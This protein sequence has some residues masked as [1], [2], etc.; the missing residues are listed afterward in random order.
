M[1]DTVTQFFLPSNPSHFPASGAVPDYIAQDA[2]RSFNREPFLDLDGAIFFVMFLGLVFL[3]HLGTYGALIFSLALSAYL[4]VRPRELG[5]VIRQHWFFLLFPAYAMFSTLWSETPF[6]TLKH[7]AE[8][9]FTVLAALLLI[10]AKNQRSVINGLFLAFAVYSVISVLMG[11]E[12]AVGTS[13]TTAL[14][15]LDDSKNEQADSVTNGALISLLLLFSGLTARKASQCLLGLAIFL[16]Q[17]YAAI[18]ARSTGALAAFAA[19][20]GCFAVL[21]GFRRVHPRVRVLVVGITAISMM[22][23]ALAFLLFR[24]EVLQWLSTVFDKDATLTGRTYLWSRA[25]DLVAERPVFGRGFE[26]FWQQGN[27]DAEGLWQFGHI[28]TRR[29]FNFHNTMYDLLVELG[30]VGLTAFALT[31]LVGFGRAVSNYVSRPS[32]L[33][34]FWLSVG[35]HMVIR[36]PIET[37]G[38]YEFSFSTVLL[39]AMLA[40]TRATPQ[41][42][43][44]FSEQYRR[45]EPDEM[46]AQYVPPLAE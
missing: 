11:T 12:V 4:A 43:P 34:C 28:L 10:S 45:V 6:D 36:M 37:I 33:S 27:L 18:L 44:A 8:F 14:A 20:A 19:G 1:S 32:L 42:V 15:G 38:T 23:V 31:M 17:I 35:I 3:S 41:Y 26:A 7:A 16:V 25:R 24:S 13:G 22:L 29:G 5:K 30:W 39:F 9:I 40:S 46:P 2:E 21:S